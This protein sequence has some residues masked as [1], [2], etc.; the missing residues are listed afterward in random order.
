MKHPMPTEHRMFLF[1]RI[2][3]MEDDALT[4]LPYHESAQQFIIVWS[5]CQVDAG[6]A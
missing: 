5:T 1:R 3:E 4:Y 6:E 2:G